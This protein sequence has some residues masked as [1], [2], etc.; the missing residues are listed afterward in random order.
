VEARGPLLLPVDPV[1][2]PCD[3]L[4]LLV[5]PVNARVGEAEPDGPRRGAA[6]PYARAWL[7]RARGCQAA[8]GGLAHAVGAR[9]ISLRNALGK[10]LDCLLPLVRGQLERTPE[11]HATGL[12]SL[13]AVISASIEFWS[14]FRFPAVLFANRVLDIRLPFI[15]AGLGVGRIYRSNEPL[16]PGELSRSTSYVAYGI[17]G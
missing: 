6:S 12:C 13:A 7:E 11:S 5:E 3:V 1:V 2:A 8:N 16:D 9:Q 4:A 15:H 14:N 17:C 10:P